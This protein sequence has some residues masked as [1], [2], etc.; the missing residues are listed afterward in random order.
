VDPV[1]P[2]G[3]TVETDKDGKIVFVMELEGVIEY[4]SFRA[5]DMYSAPVK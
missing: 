4:R 5:D 1:S 2:H 3:R